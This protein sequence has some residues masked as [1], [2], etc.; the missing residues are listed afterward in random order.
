MR[1]QDKVALIT[2]A[3]QGIGKGTAKHFAAEGARVIIAD[4]AD[5]HAG[6]TVAEIS[7]AGGE[8]TFVHA[9]VEREDDI[10]RMIA[11][12][13]ERYGRLD[14]L[15]NNAFWSKDGSVVDLE[16]ADWDRT[17]NILVRATYLGCK[18]AVPHMVA[19]GGGAI[20]NIAS[21]HGLLAGTGMAAYEAAKAAVINLSRQIAVDYGPAGIRCNTI[22]PGWIVVER[23]ANLAEDPV[24]YARAIRPIPLRRA[25]QPRDIAAAAL[26]LASDEAA[27]VTGAN[28][29][30]DGG[31]TC[32]L[33]DGVAK[34]AIDDA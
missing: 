10:R 17:H 16:R 22:S 20:V 8:A 31:L 11:V 29:V 1:L 9:D 24:Y 28:L 5:V 6:D 25:G 32:W 15:M 2:G 18:Y 26:F 30:V 33:Q 21:V 4:I 27:F 13:L 19:A 34:H 7:A 12:A 3:A 23:E 14:V